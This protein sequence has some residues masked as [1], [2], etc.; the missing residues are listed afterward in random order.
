MSNTLQGKL[1]LKNETQTFP[2]G[3]CKREFVIE[4][5]ADKYPQKIKFEAIK[6]RCDG[7][8]NIPIGSLLTVHFNIRG[9]EYNG[10]Y[11][12]SLQSWKIDVDGKA[13]DKA[14]SSPAKSSQKDGWDDEDAD[15]DIPF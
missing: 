12:V 3:F 13:P 2:S 1:I 10:K 6:E 15:D 11:Y 9:N 4:E 8:D 7:L 14:P 5:I